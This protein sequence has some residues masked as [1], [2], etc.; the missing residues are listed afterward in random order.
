MKE[1]WEDMLLFSRKERLGIGV[2]LVLMTGVM[3]FRALSTQAEPEAYDF[4]EDRAEVEAF[5][6]S[7][8][9]DAPIERSPD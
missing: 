2:L 5:M 9:E 4:S 3:L 6:A 8:A 1:F 7:I